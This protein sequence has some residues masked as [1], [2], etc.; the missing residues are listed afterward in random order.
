MMIISHMYTAMTA[1]NCASGRVSPQDEI[2]RIIKAFVTKSN[3]LLVLVPWKVRAVPVASATD[4][5]DSWVVT[6]LP[7][8]LLH[9][10]ISEV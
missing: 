1:R 4:Q 10:C 6:I 2:M 7:K 5:V 9:A 8:V 3:W